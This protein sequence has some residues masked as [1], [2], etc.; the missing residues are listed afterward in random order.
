LPLPEVVPAALAERLRAFPPT[1]DGLIFH[2]STGRPYWQ[3]HYASR[4]VAQVEHAGLL[5]GTTSHDLRH[6][7]ASVLI[8]VG[9]S[10]I[11]VAELLGHD[12]AT[13][14]LSTY[15]HLMPGNEDRTP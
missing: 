14:V 1:P 7:Y 12:N 15:A 9:E 3:E 10:V 4:V 5:A 11:A 2:T 6:H 13:L 8:A